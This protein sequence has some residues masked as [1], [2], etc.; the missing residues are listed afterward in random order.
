VT[1]LVVFTVNNRPE[2]LS[3][4][5]TTWA[6][7]RGVDQVDVAF[8]CEP[9]CPAAVTLC[10]GA[11]WARTTTTVVNPER[12]GVLGNPWHALDAGF[13]T[14]A[15]F[16][17]LAEE[18][19]PVADDILE[20]FAWAAPRFEADPQV[21]MVCAHQLGPPHPGAAPDVVLAGSHFSPIVWGT[22]ADRW[23]DW[24]RPTWD[25]D[26]RARGWDW[27]LN[28]L[29]DARH[30]TVISPAMSRSQHIGQYGG[31]HCTPGFYPETVSATFRSHYP[32]QTYRLLP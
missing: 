8:R 19:T 21:G 25:F 31:A 5:L 9:G 11:H 27:N 28:A 16:V 13:A 26:Y 22:W 15:R 23:R 18:D 24:I 4:T 10:Q 17:V 12:Y 7:V 3:D 2:Y 20:F 29:I 1:P 30:L 6:G 32:P 14:G